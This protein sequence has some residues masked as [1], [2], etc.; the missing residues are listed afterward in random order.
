MNE[1]RGDDVRE[2]PSL[3]VG[4]ADE[5]NVTEAQVSQAAVDQL[6]RGA[7]CAAPEVA[8]VDESDREAD[9]T[10]LRGDSGADDPAADHEQI[11]APLGELRSRPFPAHA[12]KE[13]VRIA[14]RRAGRSVKI[15]ST[16]AATSARSRCSSLT[17]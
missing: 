10:C 14:R 6:R 12:A 5:P 9:S 11:E 3:V 17:V 13:P 8:L 7:G 1:V 2:R 4:L 15:P 16:P